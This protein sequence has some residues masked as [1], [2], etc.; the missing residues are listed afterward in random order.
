MCEGKTYLVGQNFDLCYLRATQDVTRM[1]GCKPTGE[2]GASQARRR[3]L[4]P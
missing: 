2:Q 3:P 4:L 1:Q